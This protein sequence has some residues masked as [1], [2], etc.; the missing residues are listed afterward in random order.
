MT[1]DKSMNNDLQLSDDEIESLLADVNS[2]DAPGSSRVQDA[3]SVSDMESDEE[4]LSSTDKQTTLAASILTQS[5]G[6]SSE[7]AELTA[8]L[9]IE[10]ELARINDLFN[11]DST[12]E[13]ALKEA[14]NLDINALLEEVGDVDVNDLSNFFQNQEENQPEAPKEEV[15]ETSNVNTDIEE[16][17]DLVLEFSIDDELDPSLKEALSFSDEPTEPQKIT[18]E[19][20][21]E[22]KPT[23]QSSETSR[24]LG[25]DLTQL[26]SQETNEYTEEDDYSYDEDDND[27]H[28]SR[29]NVKKALS[30][31]AIIL[32]C[33][34]TIG[35]GLF[36]YI[37]TLHA[38]QE[39]RAA[40]GLSDIAMAL[41]HA[42]ITDSKP[43]YVA[44]D[45]PEFILKEIQA[46]LP[47]KYWNES[48]TTQSGTFGLEAYEIRIFSENDLSKF[49]LIAKPHESWTQTLF[50]KASIILP[51]HTM[52][53]YR[54]TNLYPW[55]QL[56]GRTHK[57]NEINPQDILNLAKEEQEIL[58]T[59]LASDENGFLPPKELALIDEFYQGKLYNAPRYYPITQPLI[60]EA[61]NLDS[62]S[63]SLLAETAARYHYLDGLVCYT[64]EGPE[65][66]EVAAKSLTLYAPKSE[67][68]LGY[69]EIDQESG[70]VNKAH[71]LPQQLSAKAQKTLDATLPNFLPFK[72]VSSSANT[73]PNSPEVYSESF[74]TS[75]P[76]YTAMK[77]WS[78]KREKA[79]QN[80]SQKIQELF[81]SNN[82][83]E[84]GDFH[85]KHATLL[86][87]YQTINEQFRDTISNNLSDLYSKYVHN[88]SSQSISDAFFMA[89]QANHFQSFIPNTLKYQAGL[90]KSGLPPHQ[91]A[92]ALISKLEL[93]QNFTEVDHLVSQAVDIIT[94]QNIRDL[95]Q[96]LSLQNSL[97]TQVLRTIGRFLLSPDHQLSSDTFQEH[98][99]IKLDSIL[100]KANIT[101]DE[102]RDFYLKEFDLLIEKHRTPHI[103]TGSVD[104]PGSQVIE[105]KIAKIPLATLTPRS[106]EQYLEGAARLGQQII[107]SQ[108]NESPTRQRDDKLL[109]AI[110]L[111]SNGT[112]S[113]RNLWSDILK[114]RQ[115]LTETPR[116][117]I[118]ELLNSDL[119]F[120]KGQQPISSRIRTRLE[121]Y[122]HAK[123]YL[124][125]I[126]D[127]ALYDAQYELFKE[128]QEPNLKQVI[129]D[130][131]TI[132]NMSMSLVNNYQ[133]YIYQIEQFLDQ[134]HQA[135]AEGY[136]TQHRTYHGIAMGQISDQLHSL[137]NL[138]SQ[139][140]SLAS[141]LS[142]A[143]NSHE[144]IAREELQKLNEKSLLSPQDV[145]NLQKQN[146]MINYPSLLSDNLSQKIT[147]V[148]TLDLP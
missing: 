27:T 35:F 112:D 13:S 146:N 128:T 122:I 111:L 121:Q 18:E 46:S 127:S 136:L 61:L 91:E 99:R 17:D 10:T 139:L 58:L 7:D 16:E 143:A 84:L 36:F 1:D 42:H 59:S 125:S 73:A 124:A 98:N 145:N 62:D 63:N 70:Q 90:A 113:N 71:L 79:L 6:I 68:L 126:S 131:Q 31:G 34:A 95:E 141:R 66:A 132:Q 133:Q 88:E 142:N 130:T 64:T 148:I 89:I 85:Q 4:N 56:L 134:Y 20:A 76:F 14:Q 96:L 83:Q 82:Q 28:S 29:G 87:E 104:N 48:P 97:R 102:E 26:P 11:E 50:P 41:T 39:V 135:R 108:L 49:L 44:P 40:Q 54:S 45:D 22:Q 118:T 33:S 74:S 106:S 8:Q 67:L 105:E 110:N 32:L 53:L 15:V 116:L 123:R 77:Q 114:A 137:N 47:A 117:K 101:E 119:G 72:A 138:K 93:A 109:E 52:K 37:S 78:S 115:L 120:Q 94:P 100:S 38:R 65:V 2:L 129:T 92:A 60:R 24:L 81:E 19:N 21:D 30:I 51:S 69:V 75:H 57:L 9:D 55:T 3:P 107:V 25:E 5:E 12:N 80:V 43:K 147:E 144:Q 23:F 140:E 103:H 86:E